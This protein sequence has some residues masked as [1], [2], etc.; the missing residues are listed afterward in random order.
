MSNY[1]DFSAVYDVLTQEI[2]YPKRAGYFDEVIRRHGGFRGILLELGCGT[3]SLCEEM[4]RL[5]YDVIGVDNSPEMLGCAMEKRM[6]SGLDITY[7]CQDMTE[8]DL[9][10]SVDV[11]ISALDSLNH[12]TSY[13]DFCRAIKKAAFFLHPDGV[14]VFD[15]NTV[16]KH[17]QVLRNNTFV[18]DLDEVY[19]VWQNTLR[20]GNLVEMTLDFFLP[21]EKGRYTR[22]EDSFG[23]RAYTHDQVLAALE[24]AGLRLEAVYDADSFSPPAPDSERLV[25][26]ARFDPNRP[27]AFRQSAPASPQRN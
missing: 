15:L 27:D 7:I 13:E 21:D 9:Y 3:G 26:A 4:A 1:M 8:L 19:C 25:Y 24:A 5:G 22:R 2:D 20:E 18:Y 23:E 6:A 12:L 11:V 17:Q 14:M 16:Y 10:G